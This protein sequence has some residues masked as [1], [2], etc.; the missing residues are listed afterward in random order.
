MLTIGIVDNDRFALTMLAQTVGRAVA[1]A[2]VVWAVEFGAL[3]LHHCVYEGDDAMPDVLLLDMSLTDIPGPDVCRRIREA[4]DRTAI[5]CITSYSLEHYRRS[6][7][8][9]GAQGLIS[10]SVTPRELAEAIGGVAR[11][12]TF[13]EGFMTA[14]NAKE[15]LSAAKRPAV[16]LSRREKEVLRLYAANLGTEEIAAKLDIKAS[17]VFVVMKHAKAKLGVDTRSEAIRVFLAT[18]AA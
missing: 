9:A 17:T 1:G 13:G 8:E 5:L 6:A 4:Q 10:K 18:H 16:G 12:G 2:K 3:A 7:I 11:N 15:A 14:Q